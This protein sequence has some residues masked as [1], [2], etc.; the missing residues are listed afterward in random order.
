MVFE[1]ERRQHDDARGPD[2]GL[3]VLQEVGVGV[4]LLRALE[5]LHV[6]EQVAD[7]EG[8]QEDAGHG[9]DE[10]LTDLALPEDGEPGDLDRRCGAGGCD[11]HHHPSGAEG[12]TVLVSIR[13]AAEVLGREP[14]RLGRRFY[15]SAPCEG[16]RIAPK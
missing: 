10:L 11:A 6:A 7:D 13:R 9:G 2:D 14:G 4:E 3:G 1:D 15:A 16:R 12:D 5:C 8:E